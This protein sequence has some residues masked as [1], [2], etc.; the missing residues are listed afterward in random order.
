MKLPVRFA[1]VE[2]V[3]LAD[4]MKDEDA[5]IYGEG[6]SLRGDAL[7]PTVAVRAKERERTQ[8]AWAAFVIFFGIL[9]LLW[10]ATRK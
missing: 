1:D 4:F 5:Q 8:R 2:R 6:I 7:Q 3:Q 9:V 10:V